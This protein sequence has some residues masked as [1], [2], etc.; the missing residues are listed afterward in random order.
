MGTYTGQDK[1]LQYLFQNGG[2]GGGSNV[3]PNPQGDA[4]D[5]L[6]K[7]QI[8]NTIYGLPTAIGAVGLFVDTSRVIKEAT[9]ITAN[10]DFSYTAT[11]D[12]FV[13]YS[14]VTAANAQASAKIDDVQVFITYIPSNV[15]VLT[16]GDSAY[17]KRGQTITFRQSYTQANGS[18]T[19]YGL[20]RGSEGGIYVPACYSSEERQVGVWRDGKPLY[21]KTIDC[22]YAPNNSTKQT[23]HNISNIDKIVNHF[24]MGWSDVNNTYYPIPFVQRSNVT[25]QIQMGANRTAIEIATG[26]NLFTAVYIY[27]TIQY[28]KTTDTAGSGIWTPS[29]AYAMHYS[30]DEQVIGT[31]LGETLYQKTVDLGAL[32]NATTKEVLHNISNLDYVTSCEITAKNPTTGIQITIPTAN[33]AYLN[34]QIQA[35]TSDTKVHIR[36]AVDYSAYSKANATLRYTKTA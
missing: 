18:Y 5:E 31:Y 30:T 28:T 23:L 19:V 8:E 11:E 14:L 1:R 36:T 27:A 32:P 34:Q 6:E 33:T 9:S 2:G 15:G 24:G 21:Q 26:S 3:I 13:R 12:C 10:T 7:L 20:L 4:T 35:W 22:G 25:Y 16:L 17:L 29:G